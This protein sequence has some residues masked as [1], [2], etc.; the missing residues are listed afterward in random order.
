LLPFEPLSA[1][2]RGNDV[3]NT[4]CRGVLRHPIDLRQDAESRNALLAVIASPEGQGRGGG[5]G[6]GKGFGPAL[7]SWTTG[8]SGGCCAP[9]S[10][11]KGGHPA[12]RRGCPPFSSAG[13]GPGARG[14]QSRE[15]PNRRR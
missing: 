8:S 14:A 9:V 3:N 4:R 2:L 11:R 7:Q 13:C 10:T 6:K 1:V 12:V 5:K 15:L